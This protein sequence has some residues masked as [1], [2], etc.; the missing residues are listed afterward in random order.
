MSIPTLRIAVQ[1]SGRLSDKSLSLLDQSGIDFPPSSRGLTSR[2]TNFPLELLKVRDDDIP[3][4]VATGIAD[5]AIVGENVLLESERECQIVKRLGFGKCRLAI[6]APKGSPYTR[7]SEISGCRIATSHPKLLSQFLASNRINADV[8]E[9][10]GSVEIAPALGISDLIADLV[11]SGETLLQNG[12]VEIASVQSFEACLIS[13]FSLDQ[14]KTATRDRFLTRITAVLDA[15]SI[16]YITLNAPTDKLPELLSILPGLKS[17][18][19]LPHGDGEWLS[20]HTVIREENFWELI[21][22]L[23]ARGAQGILVMPIEKVLQ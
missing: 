9:I 18:S 10:S 14:S 20:I 17:P 4:Y 19:I 16:K 22:S 8:Y 23:Q 13:G 6:A 3:G 11:S 2:A 1:R 5:L 21:E 12:L 7:I 15:K